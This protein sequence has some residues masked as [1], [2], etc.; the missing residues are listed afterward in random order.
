VLFHSIVQ[1]ATQRG[2]GNA[3][4]DEAEGWE[5]R[6]DPQ[7]TLTYAS[8]PRSFDVLWF[9]LPDGELRPRPTN[10]LGVIHSVKYSVHI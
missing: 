2:N 3:T 6:L 10:V 8:Q 9:Y 7:Y 4:R 1:A 5:P